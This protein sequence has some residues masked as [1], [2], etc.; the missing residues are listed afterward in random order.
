MRLLAILMI[1]ASPTLEY[2]SKGDRIGHGKILPDKADWMLEALG[3]LAVIFVVFAGVRTRFQLVR[4]AYWLAFGALGATAV[5]GIMI[6]V[7]DPGPVFAGLRNY[8]RALPWFFV[9]AVFLFTDRDLRL[10]L[11]LIVLVCL[12]QLPLAVSQRLQT[13]QVVAGDKERTGDI[14]TGTMQIS[15][16]L[17]IFLISAACALAAFAIR[18]KLGWPRFLLLLVLILTPTTINETKGS[19]V[20]LPIGLLTTYLVAAPRGRR[21]KQMLVGI[22]LLVIFGSIFVP[23]YD[24]FQSQ[25]KIPRSI[26]EFVTQEDRLQNYLWKDQELGTR[27]AVGRGD[28]IAVPLQYLSRD[29]ATLFFGLGLGNAS[30]SAFGEGFSGRYADLF[31][32][33]LSTAFTRVVLELGL[34]GVVFLMVVYWLI[35]TDACYVATRGEGVIGTLAAGWAGVT[36]IMAASVYYKDITAHA[37]LSFLFW[38]LSGLVAAERMRMSVRARVRAEHAAPV[39]YSPASAAS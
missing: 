37:S 30:R 16:I 34:L 3:V 25:Q 10:Q 17:S 39:G 28:A 13:G 18:K 24:Y 26:G 15:S 9:P 36:V 19:L 11:K 5:C 27:E 33:F 35:F 31:E 21:V 38:Y 29:P 2:L 8:L 7:T 32:P 20:L 4:P 14:V 1:L 6:N 22:W 23:A 12:V